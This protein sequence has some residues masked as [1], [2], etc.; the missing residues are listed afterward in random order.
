[1][2]Y[3]VVV[4]TRAARCS[5]FFGLIP[6]R[7][8][9]LYLETIAKL[10]KLLEATFSLFSKGA[11]KSLNNQTDF[12]SA[13]RRFDPL[14]PQPIDIARQI[15]L[16]SGASSERFCRSHRTQVRFILCFCT[17]TP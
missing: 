8:L 14:P 3:L 13:I 15:V 16:C 5:R 9:L 11:L 7:G 12:D 6:L 2:E 10:L 1:M 4:G 17:F